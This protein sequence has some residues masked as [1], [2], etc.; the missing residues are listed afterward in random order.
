[1]DILAIFAWPKSAKMLVRE[2]PTPGDGD[3][4]RAALSTL[5]GR[6]LRGSGPF[7]ALPPWGQPRRF[8]AFSAGSAVLSCTGDFSTFSGSACGAG[9]AGAS[10]PIPGI[11]DC[12]G[13]GAGIYPSPQYNHLLSCHINNNRSRCLPF[14]TH[15]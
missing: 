12:S 5:A 7:S 8:V 1:M 2:L 3:S 4:S 10:L 9:R 14:F 6:L 15:E 11:T 13:W